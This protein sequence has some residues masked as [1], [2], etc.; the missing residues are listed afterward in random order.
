M[1]SKE[2]SLGNKSDI[3]NEQIK[4][5][6]QNNKV[7]INWDSLVASINIKNKWVKGE[8]SRQSKAWNTDYI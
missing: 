3:K 6:K 5:I 1:G 4:N 8:H 7:K 2:Y